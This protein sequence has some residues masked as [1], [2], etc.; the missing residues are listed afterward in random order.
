M[1]ELPF[2]PVSTLM[3]LDSWPESIATQ[4]SPTK[5]DIVSHIHTSVRRRTLKE[6]PYVENLSTSE[7]QTIRSVQVQEAPAP[8]SCKHAHAYIYMHTDGVACN[9]TQLRSGLMTSASQTEE[10]DSHWPEYIVLQVFKPYASCR[11]GARRQFD[12]Q[13]L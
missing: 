7:E 2:L 9:F 3:P 11:Q 12:L 13:K 6:N 10:T 5:N 8:F 1:A 4:G